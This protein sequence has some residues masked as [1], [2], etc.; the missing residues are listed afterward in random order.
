MTI[1]RT[2]VSEADES[3]GPLNGSESIPHLHSSLNGC[4]DRNGE[5]DYD[6][7]PRLSNGH[8]KNDSLLREVLS[9]DVADEC[10]QFPSGATILDEDV[11]R[12]SESECETVV[13]YVD[14]FVIIGYFL[15]HMFG[16]LKDFSRRLGFEEK[17]IIEERGNLGFTPLY[18]SWEAFMTR[19]VY[20]RIRDCWNRPI[21]R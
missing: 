1:H 18:S 8:V 21:C 6:A 12:T 4:S 16:Y 13:S 19:N 3:H 7:A 10:R 9:Q 20:V 17:K 14:Y 15:L 5:G 2:S 11:T